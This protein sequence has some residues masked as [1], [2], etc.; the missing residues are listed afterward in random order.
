LR[1]HLLHEELHEALQFLLSHL[2]NNEHN[3]DICRMTSILPILTKHKII[4]SWIK[5]MAQ[6][7]NPKDLDL[8]YRRR[9]SLETCITLGNELAML[10][11]CHGRQ[12]RL[13]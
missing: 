5:Q 12:C 8:K 10:T 13:T 1:F 9:K 4:I 11:Q 7:H 3:P 2:E 6:R